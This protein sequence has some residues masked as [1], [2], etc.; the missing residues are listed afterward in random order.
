M[1]AKPQASCAPHIE[2]AQA[3]RR[4]VGLSDEQLAEVE[5]ELRKGPRASGFATEMWTLSRV[6]EV[7]ES[8]PSSPAVAK[9]ATSAKAGPH[10]TA[11]A[12]SAISTSPPAWS[13]YPPV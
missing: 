13:S 6:S 12:H 4:A 2:S 8:S 9:S 5:V 11:A 10:P 7:N 1:R 3:G